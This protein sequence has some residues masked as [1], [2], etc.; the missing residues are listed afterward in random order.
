MEDMTACVIDNGSRTIKAGL[1][2]EVSPSR[3]FSAV[4]AR[5]KT[6]E[7][8]VLYVGDEAQNHVD[9]CEL[10]SPIH[11]RT[12][13]SFE[14]MERLWYHTFHNELMINPES[15]PVLL[16]EATLNPKKKKKKK[17]KKVLCVD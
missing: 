10:F 1:A 16:S 3:C 2:G 15:H 14:D 6:S 9:T 8:K 17:K 5:S 11:H 4:V 13:S 7:D 12:I